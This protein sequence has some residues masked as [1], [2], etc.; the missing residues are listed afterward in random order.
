MADQ[1]N[2]TPKSGSN[3]LAPE[4]EPVTPTSPEIIITSA[5]DSTKD[6]EVE[7]AK[8]LLQA[9]HDTEDDGALPKVHSEPAADAQPEFEEEP[10]VSPEDDEFEVS[11]EALE[12]PVSPI[13]D[14]EEDEKSV[15]SSRFSDSDSDE[16]E[17]RGRA[18]RSSRDRYMS[19]SR[20]F[21]TRFDS[22][23][24]LEKKESDRRR[25]KEGLAKGERR[26]TTKSRSPLAIK[27]VTRKG[28]TV[29]VTSPT[30][31]TITITDPK[32]VEELAN[33][34]LNLSPV[35]KALDISQDAQDAI[36]R[37]F[38]EQEILK[39]AE[40]YKNGPKHTPP[41]VPARPESPQLGVSAD[42]KTPV[43]SN[44]PASQHTRLPGVSAP[45]ETG[46][47][48]RRSA[49]KELSG[50]FLMQ[51]R[52]DMIYGDLRRLAVNPSHRIAGWTKDDLWSFIRTQDNKILSISQA[53]HKNKLQ[54]D[55]QG[56]VT[57]QDE[58][59]FARSEVE[60]IK[61]EFELQTIANEQRIA[62]LE[63]ELDN[64]EAENERLLAEQ[65]MNES[66]E[67]ILK[68]PIKLSVE[69]S[70]ALAKV[71]KH[72]EQI[73]TKHDEVSKGMDQLRSQLDLTQQLKDDNKELRRN[74]ELL[75]NQ[76]EFYDHQNEKL[77]HRMDEQE[78]ENDQITKAYKMLQKENAQLTARVQ[79]LQAARR[80]I[81]DENTE[82]KI[83]L[84]LCQTTK[85]ELEEDKLVAAQP[86]VGPVDSFFS[87]FSTKGIGSEEESQTLRDSN[88]SLSGKNSALER[89]LASTREE[90]LKFRELYNAAEE[91]RVWSFAH[92][93]TVREPWPV[94]TREHIAQLI[95]SVV[96]ENRK[97]S[98]K[99]SKPAETAR[100]IQFE[101]TGLVED[102]PLPDLLTRDQVVTWFAAG[103]GI[104]KIFE[105]I[106]A[107]GL[108][109]DKE[110]EQEILRVLIEQ[111]LCYGNYDVFSTFV[112]ADRPF[113][114]K[115]FIARQTDLI[116]VMDG[117]EKKMIKTETDLKLAKEKVTELEQQDR[118][119]STKLEEQDHDL[120][121]AR[122][123]LETF[124]TYHGN[125]EGALEELIELRAT[126]ANLREELKEVEDANKELQNQ[127]AYYEK[128]LVEE[129]SEAESGGVTVNGSTDQGTCNVLAHRDLEARIHDLEKQNQELVACSRDQD[130][131]AA[132]MPNSPACP[133]CHK[134][135]R[136][137]A[138]LNLKLRKAKGQALED[139]DNAGS[140]SSPPGASPTSEEAA[141]A[142][143]YCND[144]AYLS[145]QFGDARRQNK[146]LEEKLRLRKYE[147]RGC[148]YE[149]D[150]ARRDLDEANERLQQA[151]NDLADAQKEIQR[152]RAEDSSASPGSTST[153]PTSAGGASF[154]DSEKDDR[155][156]ELEAL[157]ERS[158]QSLSEKISDRLIGEWGARKLAAPPADKENDLW[159]SFSTEGNA[160]KLAA[161]KAQL[162]EQVAII[163]NNLDMF[164]AAA[165][166]W[167]DEANVTASQIENA[168]SVGLHARIE[169]LQRQVEV[170]PGLE[171][172][173]STLVEEKKNLIGRVEYF[174][175]GK[176][177]ECCLATRTELQ[178]E[179][180]AHAATRKELEN[181]V[182]AAT[183][184]MS[185][186]TSEDPCKDV[187]DELE[188]LKIEHADLEDALRTTSV[189]NENNKKLLKQ[190][191]IQ[192]SRVKAT[193]DAN[194]GDPCKDIR[195]ELE[196][197]RTRLNELQRLLD[198]EKAKKPTNVSAQQ[199]G[200]LIQQICDLEAQIAKTKSAHDTQAKIDKLVQ[201]VRDDAV[202]IAELNFEIGKL[203][204]I[205]KVYVLAGDR[206]GPPENDHE[207]KDTILE[208]IAAQTQLK[209][210][211]DD[212]RLNAPAKK[213]KPVEEKKEELKPKP[214]GL[215][216]SVFSVFKKSA[217]ATQPAAEK[218][219]EATKTEET[220]APEA[221]TDPE[222]DP[223]STY[224]KQLRDVK[225]QVDA[226][227]MLTLYKEKF[228]RE[229]EIVERKDK[230]NMQLK[231]KLEVVLNDAPTSLRKRL[232][233]ALEA[234]RRQ[235]NIIGCN[236]IVAAQH[237]KEM[238][239]LYKKL[240]VL[241]KPDQVIK[242][243]MTKNLDLEKKLDKVQG[244]FFKSNLESGK[245][246]NFL[247]R[248]LSELYAARNDWRDSKTQ[249]SKGFWEPAEKVKNSKTPESIEAAEAK[250][251]ASASKTPESASKTTESAPKTA[252][253]ETGEDF[254]GTVENP[255]PKITY[256][257]WPQPP[258]RLQ[259]TFDDM[260]DANE[261]LYNN[262]VYVLKDRVPNHPK[263]DI[264]GLWNEVQNT[265]WQL[266]EP[267]K[268]PLY[269]TAIKKSNQYT[270]NEYFLPAVWA[271]ILVLEHLGYNHYTMPTLDFIF[272]HERGP[273]SF[274][275][276][277]ASLFFLFLVIYTFWLWHQ[278]RGIFGKPNGGDGGDDDSDDKSPKDDPCKDVKKEL[279]DT[280]AELEKAKESSD[281]DKD[282]SKKDDSKKDDSN[283]DNSDP[284]TDIRNELA[285]TTAKLNDAQA[286]LNGEKSVIDWKNDK[287]SNSQWQ[288]L[289][290]TKFWEVAGIP[291]PRLSNAVTFG[292]FQRNGAGASSEPSVHFASQIGS[293]SGS[294]SA[295]PPYK[296]K[297]TEEDF[298]NFDF[299]AYLKS[300]DD[301]Y[302][303]GFDKY[304]TPEVDAW[305]DADNV[306][307]TEK[308]GS[309]SAAP[310]VKDDV[311]T[312]YV[313]PFDFTTF[314]PPAEADLNGLAAAAGLFGLGADTDFTVNMMHADA[315][316]IP[317]ATASTDA[318]KFDS[319]MLKTPFEWIQ[320]LNAEIA[321][322][323]NMQPLPF[324]YPI[325]D[326]TPMSYADF[327]QNRLAAPQ[328]ANN[329]PIWLSP[330]RGGD[331]TFDPSTPPIREPRRYKDDFIQRLKMRQV[332]CEQD[333]NEQI[334]KKSLNPDPSA[335]ESPKVCK[336][337]PLGRHGADHFGSPYARP[338]RPAADS[339]KN[340]I[341]GPY[342]PD[343][344]T[345]A[346]AWR[347]YLRKHPRLRRFV[348]G[349]NPWE[350]SP[351]KPG[352][353][354]FG[355]EARQRKS[356]GGAYG[357][358][359]PSHGDL[360]A[361]RASYALL[362][363][364]EQDLKDI[365]EQRRV[366]TE[367]PEALRGAGGSASGRPGV[368]PKAFEPF[369]QIPDLLRSPGAKAVPAARTHGL[370]GDKNTAAFPQIPEQS[371]TPGAKAAPAAP[372]DAAHGASGAKPS[373]AFPQIPDHLRNFRVG[374]ATV[375]DFNASGKWPDPCKDVKERLAEAQQELDL[376]MSEDDCAEVRRR[377]KELYEELQAKTI[378]YDP[379]REQLTRVEAE[380]AGEKKEHEAA[381][382]KVA[383]A[384][385][386]TIKTN[387]QQ[388]ADAKA[389][390][391]A[392]DSAAKE[393]EKKITAAEAQADQFKRRADE[394]RRALEFEKSRRLATPRVQEENVVPLSTQMTWR[395]FWI[396]LALSILL[397]LL[398]FPYT[399]LGQ[400]PMYQD[401]AL[402]VTEI[403]W[404]DTIESTRGYHGVIIALGG[405]V[406]VVLMIW[407]A[408][409]ASANRGVSPYPDYYD[410]NDDGNNGGDGKDD[411]EK[412]NSPK[413]PLSVFLPLSPRSPTSKRSNPNPPKSPRGF[414]TTRQ[415]TWKHSYISS[416]STEPRAGVSA[417][418]KTTDLSPYCKQLE[419]KVERLE[420]EL[421][422]SRTKVS[423]FT[424]SAISS[425]D[426]RPRA[427]P[428]ADQKRQALAHSA[429]KSIST[430]PQAAKKAAKT[431][432]Q[433]VDPTADK[434]VG[435]WNKI[436]TISLFTTAPSSPAKTE[437][438]LKAELDNVK[439]ELED[440]KKEITANKK[441]P[442][443]EVEGWDPV[444]TSNDDWMDPCKHVNEELERAKKQLEEARVESSWLRKQK[445][446]AEK[447]RDG[448][449]VDGED[450]GNNGD[451][452]YPPP[453]SLEL[454]FIVAED[455]VKMRDQQLEKAAED[456]KNCHQANVALRKRFYD[457][458]DGWEA[459]KLRVEEL[460][461]A[462]ASK[463]T[464]SVSTQTSPVKIEGQP[465]PQASSGGIDHTECQKRIRD[466]LTQRDQL[467]DDR[468][469][470]DSKCRD[471]ESEARQLRD[472]LVVLD[473]KSKR[474]E[475]KIDA[476]VRELDH[477]KGM[478]NRGA[479]HGMCL[480]GGKREILEKLVADY[481]RD[482]DQR[483]AQHEETIKNLKN[484][485]QGLKNDA[486]NRQD[487]AER[488]KLEAQQL[489][490]DLSDEERHSREL[491][492]KYRAALANEKKALDDLETVRTQLSE[493]ERAKVQI[494]E[495]SFAQERL[496][497]ANREAKDAKDQLDHWVNQ[498]ELNKTP[499]PENVSS[500]PEVAKL[501]RFL[502]D[503]T[504]HIEMLLSQ[505]KRVEENLEWYR[506]RLQRAFE[507][508]DHEQCNAMEKMYKQ[509]A[510]MAEEARKEAADKNTQM[511]YDFLDEKT[512][513]YHANEAK[514]AA[515]K[516]VGELEEKKEA[517]AK[518]LEDK[519]KICP[520]EIKDDDEGSA[521]SEVASKALRDARLATRLAEAETRKLKLERDRLAR[522][523]ALLTQ[524]LER[525]I[526]T[527]EHSTEP[528][529]SSALPHTPISLDSTDKTKKQRP[530][531]II[532]NFSNLEDP[533]YEGLVTGGMTSRLPRFNPNRLL[534]ILGPPHYLYTPKR[535][536]IPTPKPPYP[537]FEPLTPEGRRRS[538][539]RMIS[540]PDREMALAEERAYL[541]AVRAVEFEFEEQR[542]D[543]YAL[544]FTLLRGKLNIPVRDV[545]AR[546]ERVDEEEGEEKE[547][548]KAEQNSEYKE[549]A[550]G[551]G[552]ESSD[553]SLDDEEFNVSFLM[554]EEGRGDQADK[555]TEEI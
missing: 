231:N 45:A 31:G 546:L 236:E 226:F 358:K 348:A 196:T 269:Q 249:L 156:K 281:K 163:Q 359:F 394:Y 149:T 498:F 345:L 63:T 169:N 377:V 81:E 127:V 323:F 312:D 424:Q 186:G 17:R 22:Q 134:M 386:E 301:V 104:S 528:K 547:D 553:S 199:H 499:V 419:D 265:R 401:S 478:Y 121:Q 316:S 200:D 415:Q 143:P 137:I 256:D 202:R 469:E 99:S 98:E 204:A 100:D 409:L 410:D 504:N 131:A 354:D 268:I 215:I 357:L 443:A 192:S 540:D 536:P 474:L 365:D 4:Q 91:Q 237:H 482:G 188:A 124:E 266:T 329:R 432:E 228:L 437:Q 350:R 140:P 379:V 399:T 15:T 136:T 117:L 454:K 102:A 340:T 435:L 375:P 487:I 378:L 76:V 12:R 84:D 368:K 420:R 178:K 229:Q 217:T 158:Q 353:V 552:E 112:F 246:L 507:A 429:I 218:P 516:R 541:A 346:S 35:N 208:L 295:P 72:F 452:E 289:Q 37:A 151:Q 527:L 118:E 95:V 162:Q 380:L 135:R 311:A 453:G 18:R 460:K 107:L 535:A 283:K 280:K 389:H 144:C 451:D 80:D 525:K 233:E 449:D 116:T 52:Y 36:Q 234:N 210:L 397:S 286:Q 148:N 314:F 43:H 300:P 25:S 349:R 71:E 538:A 69:A 519:T 122:Q 238:A 28:D 73:N 214:K 447:Q 490:N 333:Y 456:L 530:A 275:I 189:E 287:R 388:K 10:L 495:D 328:S 402:S 85:S 147:I 20:T 49:S 303:S 146:E 517:L 381:K 285:T 408:T 205:S 393:A 341:P 373:A 332:C 436:T 313:S 548:T 225:K 361:W 442:G 509:Q 70:E 481:E 326:N 309:K 356:M 366:V 523:N 331:G 223:C 417:G 195:D 403:L 193:G 1:G 315:A 90:S 54:S 457:E 87:T 267:K 338:R 203:E 462:A 404:Y 542:S 500:D 106:R 515:E 111:G 44:N 247:G 23:E 427:G 484:Q 344:A 322:D 55:I 142:E 105:E 60:R 413:S 179:I 242:D 33:G 206:H 66:R 411:D 503:R 61:S 336:H 387:E 339:S 376:L 537:S 38:E 258:P 224:K 398:V 129:R 294:R 30:H 284:C 545:R 407:A 141:S 472:Q 250:T 363:P 259:K 67:A 298:E 155:I 9:S 46:Y 75:E 183:T 191:R 3:K 554:I 310:E 88:L 327:V 330:F 390:Q 2:Q 128:E 296:L 459:E 290:N 511:W 475:S 6:E 483:V 138:D 109:L 444:E 308:L 222:N 428:C 433:K 51:K 302:W 277:W 510:E 367:I 26:H 125:P 264:T 165:K 325:T 232:T 551:E 491:A 211:I 115:E 170:I 168:E 159:D 145:K 529:I 464:S 425:I 304:P 110:T 276:R 305:V 555:R 522:E 430:A 307:A 426:L 114:R 450:E 383:V 360:T 153:A 24:K 50:Q 374:M 544:L 319:S 271:V 180:D 19:P 133:H 505:K 369:S 431:V 479:D 539:E 370:F 334:G 532:T 108:E 65:T 448:I 174:N 185:S 317:T 254:R 463:Q 123:A 154:R 130:V 526:D 97:P 520:P 42:A 83:Q 446:R 502:F 306:T 177:P 119:L 132:Q 486:S 241:L 455:L 391:A 220:P 248:Q 352:F 5:E 465:D 219:V 414:Q 230:E 288:R 53:L 318:P 273:H 251:S 445:E 274:L 351:A 187:R 272:G 492:T 439:K 270:E 152:L 468:A 362:P 32:V 213:F 524:R 182:D 494:K 440:A 194:S 278:L 113:S 47:L 438:D 166:I 347:T 471:A 253:H 39:L 64:A 489:R 262:P 150:E 126:H 255:W 56:M 441:Q 240:E 244:K 175:G 27:S 62:E 512:K 29:I 139:R 86:K 176:R 48:H 395:R 34:Q 14:E 488:C 384:D 239:A 212:Y 260:Y 406:L 292:E 372:A 77:K 467:R 93:A 89:L 21:I 282:N 161:E 94:A 342:A 190:A 371:R 343:Q 198:E 550:D 493:C 16:E 400:M 485:M 207:C 496:D 513:A 79:T 103:L 470:A 324:T 382:Q 221:E 434:G 8:D 164:E 412:G 473:N 120:E 506:K 337:R 291:G 78:L 101:R 514:K 261:K 466:L 227:E 201:R 549:E 216:Q 297:P 257:C 40:S 543:E 508:E 74:T 534:D 245:K 396:T 82:L 157:L 355:D 461:Q 293:R 477:Y 173:I 422:A 518:Q 320:T 13:E 501:Q 41:P 181:S 480:R 263:P 321:K 184:N 209:G 279:A 476:A 92:Y 497:I 160:S 335:S 243:L 418:S 11:G 172:R 416:V 405:S 197:T 421:L 171:E 58:R 167:E 252:S 392:L 531:D 533:F 364:S 235:A 521:S 458:R 96:N 385:P 57:L 299:A 68:S 59:N 7:S 423:A